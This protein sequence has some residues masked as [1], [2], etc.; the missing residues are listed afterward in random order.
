ML[1]PKND[2][3]SSTNAI[4]GMEKNFSKE[5]EHDRERRRY[6]FSFRW[7]L[8]IEWQRRL[9]LTL[10]ILDLTLGFLLSHPKSVREASA[11]LVVKFLSLLLPLACIWFG[12][13]MGDYVGTL[14]IP[15]INKPSPG[16]LVRLGGWVLLILRLAIWWLVYWE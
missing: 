6:F 11:G 4:D 8:E 14:P 7:L 15:S 3:G 16:G 9:S 5:G 2:G 12:E 13:E 10:A 1:A